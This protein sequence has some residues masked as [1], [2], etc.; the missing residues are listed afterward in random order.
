MEV[1]EYYMDDAPDIVIVQNPMSGGWFIEGQKKEHLPYIRDSFA[2][3]SKM[4]RLN[5]SA[6]AR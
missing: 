3:A 4:Y 5:S 2:K 6:W 1:T